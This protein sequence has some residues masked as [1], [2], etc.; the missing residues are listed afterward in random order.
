MIAV[1]LYALAY[2]HRYNMD[3]EEKQLKDGP[4]P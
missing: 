4:R 3:A 2:G 1:L